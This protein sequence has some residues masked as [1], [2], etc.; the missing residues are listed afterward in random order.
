MGY[1]SSNCIIHIHDS[2]ITWNTTYSH[3]C[4]NESGNKCEVN[5]IVVEYE[6]RF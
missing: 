2:V 4:I 6:Y 3:I 5:D 1:Y